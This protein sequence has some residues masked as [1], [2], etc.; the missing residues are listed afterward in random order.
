MA[1]DASA[2]EPR[3]AGRPVAPAEDAVNDPNAATRLLWKQ[4][5]TP[6]DPIESGQALF[7]LSP[8]LIRQLV[9]AVLATCPEAENLLASMPL[10]V[11]S[12]A[13]ATTSTP[14]RCQGEV[15]G[16]VLWSETL[17][18][19]AGTPGATDVYVCSSASRA[20]DTVENRVLVAALDIIVK[21]ARAADPVA[22]QAYDDQVLLRARDNGTRARHY[23]EHRAL[24]TVPRKR[25]DGRA[26]T[27][28]RAGNRRRT[29]EPALLMLDRGKHPITLNHLLA[30]TDRRT[31]WQHWVIMALSQR[32][33]ARGHPLPMYRSTPAGDLRAGR[34]VYRHP[35]IARF[36]G[37]PLHGILFER[38]LI[39]VPDPIDHPD[40]AR[41]EFELGAR[42]QGRVPVL[43]T[44]ELDIDRVVNLA[45]GTL[46]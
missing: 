36:T 39:D 14:F 24:A 23:L 12:L 22:H 3:N 7:G 19:R 35:G 31:A 41:A 20:Y 32:L 45:L 5:S 26:I 37:T 33:R 28:T 30:F 18:A 43:V 9:G 42:S 15:R 38:L 8:V 29:Y 2:V 34:L 13:I 44:S 16:P 10:L 4:L 11:R 27:K 25:P 17:A 46:G 40:L 6:I 21:A 1:D